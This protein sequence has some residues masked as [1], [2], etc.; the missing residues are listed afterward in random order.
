MWSINLFYYLLIAQHVLRTLRLFQTCKGNN[1]SFEKDTRYYKQIY[2]TI[3]HFNLKDAMFQIV[4]F[5]R[6]P[7]ILCNYANV[8]H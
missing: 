1:F 4:F 5:D 6:M 2:H 3:N 7:Q 8:A